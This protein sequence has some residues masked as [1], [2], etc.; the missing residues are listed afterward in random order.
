MKAQD[1]SEVWEIISVIYILGITGS[2]MFLVFPWNVVGEVGVWD[3]DA[4][5]VAA[6]TDGKLTTDKGVSDPAAAQGHTSADAGTAELTTFPLKTTA[7]NGQEMSLL[8]LEVDYVM[9]KNR[10]ATSSASAWNCLQVLPEKHSKSFSKSCSNEEQVWILQEGRLQGS[11]RERWQPVVIGKEHTEEHRSGKLGNSSLKVWLVD[12]RKT[13]PCSPFSEISHSPHG[14]GGCL[15][16]LWIC[17]VRG[18]MR[19]GMGR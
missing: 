10:R 16:L 12:T 19:T 1:V 7:L 4:W 9:G 3:Q 6:N 18:A 2:L 5:S 17:K 11:S 14:D 15:G 8:Y 13:I